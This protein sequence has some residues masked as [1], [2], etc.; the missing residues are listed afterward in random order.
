MGQTC[1]THGQIKNTHGS[2]VRKHEGNRP[3]QEVNT[4][5][6]HT[7]IWSGDDSWIPRPQDKVQSL[8]LVNTEV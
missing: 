8:T 1:S 6:Y 2:L 5:L 4:Q 3:R 7:E